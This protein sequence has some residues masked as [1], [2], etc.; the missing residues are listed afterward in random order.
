V[1]KDVA[2]L[3]A[4]IT[5]A[6]INFDEEEL[7]KSKIIEKTFEDDKFRECLHNPSS[8]L[9]GITVDNVRKGLFIFLKF[10][11]LICFVRQQGSR[12]LEKVCE[13]CTNRKNLLN[14][15]LKTILRRRIQ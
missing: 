7:F 11:R 14:V 4:L 13:C 10:E 5:F 9:F 8:L 6:G 3:L 12:F 1:D 2:G 15:V